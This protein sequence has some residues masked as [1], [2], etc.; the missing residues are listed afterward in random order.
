MGWGGVLDLLLGPLH[1]RA[2]KCG[3]WQMGKEGA[4]AGMS[5]QK[6]KLV[7]GAS[8]GSS[9]GL[10][11]TRNCLVNLT[12]EKKILRSRWRTKLWIHWSLAE[13]GFVLLWFNYC[14]CADILRCIIA[15]T[16]QKA[17]SRSFLRFN[18]TS[19]N[20]ILLCLK[21]QSK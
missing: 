10:K 19:E 8:V 21:N 7:K 3:F 1:H 14:W 5:N 17:F 16:N 2:H 11:C 6:Y 18:N 15:W 20:S 4:E 13:T 12:S 9:A